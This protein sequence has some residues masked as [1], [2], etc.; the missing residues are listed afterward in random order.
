MLK[1]IS[2][3]QAAAKTLKREYQGGEAYQ[4]HQQLLESYFQS[5]RIR[6]HSLKTIKQE[7]SFLSGWF[8]SHGDGIRPLYIWEAMEFVI[9]RKRISNYGKALIDSD[10][11]NKTIRS[12]LGK[13]KN[14]F[15]YVLEHPF[16]FR[17]ETPHRIGELYNRIEQPVSEYDIPQHSYD[18]EQR[19]I[20]IDPEKIYSFLGLMKT[21][22]LIAG[23]CQHIRARNYA[24]AVVA[25]QSGLRS[26]EL[27]NL[28]IKKDLFWESKKLQT[29]HAKGTKGSGKRSRI[30]LFP[31][32][33]RDTLKFYLNNHRPH[34]K[35][36]NKT[37]YLFPSK[38]GRIMTYSGIQVAL[39]EMIK[40]AQNNN[41]PIMNHMGWHNFRR[42][43][44][45]LFIERF[46]DKLPVLIT[47]LG[48]MSPNTVHCYIRHSEA[49]M[50]RKVQDVLEYG[51]L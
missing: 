22:Y 38:S 36:S 41:I 6:N 39:K 7:K 10:L 19:G 1:L 15:T 35:D 4:H 9:G 42:I 20:P 32:L 12:Y 24:M 49:W 29:R 13:L 43:F 16:V 27:L 33:A 51:G 47:L 30:T 46:P 31:S 11:S 48:H 18:G 21:K 25:T 50:D 34:I 26:D 17:G 23:K 14:Y 40:I 3:Q 8:E 2:Y 45:T 5:H 44:A 28:E 37:D